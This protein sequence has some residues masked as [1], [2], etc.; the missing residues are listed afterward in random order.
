MTYDPRMEGEGPGLT[1][2]DPAHADPDW[3]QLDKD[4]AIDDPD[5]PDY[6]PLPTERHRRVPG[7]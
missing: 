5:A 1:P 2:R 7:F 4:D 3:F 6:D